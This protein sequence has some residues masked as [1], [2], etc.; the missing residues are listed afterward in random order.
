MSADEHTHAYDH[1]YIADFVP[2]RDAIVRNHGWLTQPHG[3]WCYV[4]PP[5]HAMR[6]QGWKIHLSATPAS[7]VSVLRKAGAVLLEHRVPF[8]FAQGLKELRHLLSIRCDRGASGK[9][10]TVYPQDDDQFRMLLEKLHAATEGLPGPRILSDRPFRPDSI[11]HYRYGGFSSGQQVLGN[12]GAYDFMLVAADGSWAVDTRTPWFATPPWVSPPLPGTPPPR[13]DGERGKDQ[14][15]LDDRFVVREAI[16]HSNRGGVYRA[17]DRSSGNPVIVKEAR[18]H[19]AAE[20]DGTDARDFLRNEAE[21]LD[22]LAPLGMAPAK[23]SLFDY[24]GHLFLAEEEV[25]GTTLRFW[26]RSRAQERPDRTV[27]TERLLDLARQLVHLVAAVHDKGLVFRDLTPGNIMVTETDRLV[28][29]DPEFMARRGE[30]SIRGMTLGY[31]APD[32]LRSEDLHRPADPAGDL[33]S[34]GACLFYLCTGVD[35]VLPADAPEPRPYD[36]R[37]NAL[38]AAVAGS[39]PLLWHF[40]DLILGLMAEQPSRRWSLSRAGDL[41]DGMAELTPRPVAPAGLAAV[42]QDRLLRDGVA[43]L[44]AACTSEEH[45]LWPPTRYE[46]RMGDRCSIQSGAA[47]P[48]EVL[49]RSL[50]VAAEPDRETTET[51]RQAAHA[52]DLRLGQGERLLPGLYFGRAGAIWALYEAAGAL[53]DPELSERAIALAKRLPVCWRNPDI[54][55]G[56]AGSGMAQLHLWRQTRD[57]ELRERVLLCVESVLATRQDTDQGVAWPVPEDFDSEL[58]GIKHYGFAHGV[59]GIC[60]FLLSAARELDRPDLLE[61]AIS[62]G[63]QLVAA[64]RPSG[65]G[66]LWPSG[67]SETTGDHAVAWWCSGSG[68]IGTFLI[69][70]WR[71][72][73]IERFRTV[74]HQ[75]AIAVRHEKWALPV[76]HCHGLAGSGELL[77]DLAAATGDGTYLEWAAEQAAVLYHRAYLKDGRLVVPCEGNLEVNHSYNLGLSGALGFLHRLRHGGERWWMVDDFGLS[78]PGARR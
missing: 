59:A 10:M 32:D 69:R 31:A 20:L 21:M 70:L 76:G 43:E 27:G 8:K 42:D 15:L 16:Q 9:F 52:L 24:Q 25:P 55:H 53:G 64:G 50:A 68:G 75:A 67:D 63:H 29:I 7:A 78:E 65:E 34:L 46:H 22:L 54:T 45:Y 51:F 37:L 18:P 39:H 6:A 17:V 40:R 44:V 14:V 61:L 41:L 28:L 5:G 4:E 38:F 19:V 73:G 58:A 35:P 23:V 3:I 13:A 77:L 71:A 26:A 1:S 57:D 48:L 36:D 74:A 60:T 11:V 2:I 33:Y 47:G 72:T 30:T 62:S 49:R 12:D 56:V 66:M